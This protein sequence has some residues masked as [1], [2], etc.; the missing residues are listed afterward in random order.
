MQCLYHETRGLYSVPFIPLASD[1]ELGGGG[2]GESLRNK[3]SVSPDTCLD[4]F[5][6]LS[7]HMP[8][9]IP[10]KLMPQFHRVRLCHT[11]ILWE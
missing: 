4:H 8:M 3:L 11:Y 1:G 2:A 7:S 5:L 10:L 6:P 9:L